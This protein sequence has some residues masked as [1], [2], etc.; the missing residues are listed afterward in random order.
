M[1]SVIT[2]AE[3]C[4]PGVHEEFRAGTQH[5]RPGETAEARQ[6]R[7]AGQMPVREALHGDGKRAGGHTER[8]AD[9]PDLH[10]SAVHRVRVRQALA[11]RQAGQPGHPADFRGRTYRLLAEPGDRSPHIAGHVQTG[12]RDKTAQP[13]GQR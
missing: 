5:R 12:V 13:Q 10:E 11:V 4:P 2:R 9:G 7:H 3:S 6:V 1:L 8:L